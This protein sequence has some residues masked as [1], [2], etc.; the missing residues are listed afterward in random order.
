[1]TQ[2]WKDESYNLQGNVFSIFLMTFS[3]VYL[4]IITSKNF[5]KAGYNIRISILNT[6]N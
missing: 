4:W 1:M 5:H 6:Y 3:I 2:Y